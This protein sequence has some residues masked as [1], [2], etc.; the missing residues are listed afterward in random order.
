MIH[1]IV[2]YSLDF[3]YYFFYFQ[4]PCSKIVSTY[5]ELSTL[6]LPDLIDVFD[7]VPC[8]WTMPEQQ[9]CMRSLRENRSCL[10][11]SILVPN[12]QNIY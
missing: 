12:H 3:Y 6:Q 10:I 4:V 11:S 8:T 7:I 9:T 2:K 5:D 1:S